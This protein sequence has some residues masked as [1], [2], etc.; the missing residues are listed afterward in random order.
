M[1]K[2]RKRI[3]VTVLSC[4]TAGMLFAQVPY[5][6]SGIWEKGKGKKIYLNHFPTSTP[7]SSP[8]DS[9]IVNTDGSFHLSGELKEMQLLSVTLEGEKG[10]RSIMGDGKP[11]FLNIKDVKYS[12]KSP[13]AAF[14]IKGEVMEHDAA[15]S[16]LDFWSADFI[17]KISMGVT[18]GGIRRAEKNNDPVEKEKK[19]TELK[20]LE[21]ERERQKEAYLNQYG[22]CLA[23]PFFIV[24]NMLKGAPVYE[25]EAVYNRL[26]EKAKNTPKGIELKKNIQAMKRLSPGAPAPAFSL[27]TP[28]GESLS[29]ESLQGHIVIL[30]FWASWCGPC[31]AEMPTIK[32]IYEKYKD[33]GLKVIG[34]S[35]DNVK[36]AWTKAI[37]KVQIPWLHVSS[38]KG[39]QRCPVAQAYQVYAIPKLYI[40]DPQGRIIDKD[41]RGKELKEKIDELFINK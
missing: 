39:M 18:E 32:D 16:I 37:E 14:E 31:I 22:N 1:K 28:T 24:M 20:K 40:I 30:D 8:L 23:A 26:G 41:L 11:L 21:D 29:L 7:E 25:M 6:I 10:Y 13:S 2:H 15:K 34:I 5:Q 9:T 35:M 33:K 36:T 38:L 12:Y 19:E 27:S 17:R 4:L 3:S